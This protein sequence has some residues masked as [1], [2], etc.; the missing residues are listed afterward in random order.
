MYVKNLFDAF[1]SN[2]FL[3]RPILT[4]FDILKTQ[5]F[6]IHIEISGHFSILLIFTMSGL[7]Q[8]ACMIHRIL[9]LNFSAA[10]SRY[11]LFLVISREFHLA[12]GRLTSNLIGCRFQKSLRLLICFS[13]GE[14][15]LIFWDKLILYTRKF[16]CK[17]IV[18]MGTQG[19]TSSKI[20]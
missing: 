19:S 7:V 2:C 8:S 12:T 10:I 18:F 3:K 14:R 9:K 4:F 20:L 1:F 11:I 13:M 17:I 5:R 6:N 15:L 16:L